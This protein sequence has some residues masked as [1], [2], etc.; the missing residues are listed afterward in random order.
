MTAV[1]NKVYRFAKIIYILLDNHVFHVQV[2]KHCSDCCSNNCTT[3]NASSVSDDDSSANNE[4]PDE[5]CLLLNL[6]RVLTRIRME[7]GGKHVMCRRAQWKL[8]TDFLTAIESY[9]NIVTSEITFGSV[10]YL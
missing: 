9:Y 7:L 6:K 8:L 5:E 3:L 2:N 1:Q 10:S 4:D